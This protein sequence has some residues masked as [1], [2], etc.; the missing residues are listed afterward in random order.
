MEILKDIKIKYPE[1][2][3][4]TPQTLKQF[5]IRCLTVEDEERLK[6]SLLSP[7]KFA[8]HLNKIIWDC[9]VEKPEEI[10]T[11]DDYL[12]R[13]SI[14]DRE[15]LLFGM[16]HASYKDI[17]NYSVKC[18]QCENSFDIK[19]NI[20][21]AFKMDAWV[22]DREDKETGNIDETK[23]GLID[24]E[25]EV[26]LDVAQ[27]IVPIVKQA[28]LKRE[29][30]LMDT[31]VFSNKE[32][33]DL[34]SEMLVVDKFMIKQDSGRAQT[35]QEINN[36]LRIY[37]KLPG[38]DRKLINKTYIDNLGKYGVDLTVKTTCPKCQAEDSTPI[39]LISQFFRALYE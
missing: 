6:G 8:N 34:A 28:T 10:K 21:N 9:L 11:Y 35:Y 3:I 26:K 29:Q 20:K 15:A 5:T 33:V 24:R 30:D 31:L 22:D 36:V 16:Y 38:P 12:Q 4:V 18:S 32:S 7:N 27:N 17:T 13:I 23:P 14:K 25:F 19:V 39:D 2:Q 37:K 1:Y